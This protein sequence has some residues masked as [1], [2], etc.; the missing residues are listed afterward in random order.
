MCWTASSLM[1]WIGYSLS[2]KNQQAAHQTPL[3]ATWRSMACLIEHHSARENN[4]MV[5]KFNET[6]HVL[7]LLSGVWARIKFRKVYK[8]MNVDEKYL[9]RISYL[10]HLS[11]GVQVYSNLYPA[12]RSQRAWHEIKEAMQVCYNRNMM[13]WTVKPTAELWLSQEKMGPDLCL[14]VFNLHK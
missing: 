10:N 9:E 14:H 12:K 13:C 2:A 8:S 7:S 3:W 4:D 5:M 1:L 11:L 6:Q